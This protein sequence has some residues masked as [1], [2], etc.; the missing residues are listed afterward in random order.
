M[1]VKKVYLISEGDDEWNYFEQLNILLSN[2]KIINLKPSSLRSYSNSEH[3]L[4]LGILFYSNNILEE[5]LH[6]K[7]WSFY[8]HWFLKEKGYNIS[9]QKLV[10]K[11]NDLINKRNLS[12]DY[13][14]EIT[15]DA[16]INKLLAY[17][18]FIIREIDQANKF[19]NFII[20]NNKICKVNDFKVLIFDTD[21]G[22]NK[23]DEYDLAKLYS[24]KGNL[25][26]GYSN[27]C[28]EIFALLHLRK[29]TSKD[30]KLLNDADYKKRSDQMKA[31]YKVTKNKIFKQP[32]SS[33]AMLCADATT[34]WQLSNLCGEI[35]KLDSEYGTNLIKLLGRL[36]ELNRNNTSSN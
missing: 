5:K 30:I 22:S 8:Y 35:N 1:N 23:T 20:N 19:K 21:K 36:I 9:S 11:I 25:F 24:K 14:S 10:A 6:F 31:I 33:L 13:A 7:F 3:S 28:F 26:F 32:D 34:N 17:D 12:L 2:I 15:L 4:M 27:P 29:I 16:F 18:F